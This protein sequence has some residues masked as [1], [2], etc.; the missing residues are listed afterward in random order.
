ALYH[1]DDGRTGKLNVN[2]APTYI[3]VVF[4]EHDFINFRFTA[5]G[6]EKVN[7]CFFLDTFWQGNVQLFGND[8]KCGALYD[9]R[10]ERNE[11]DN[12]ENHIGL[13]NTCQQGVCGEYD[14][15]RPAQTYPGDVP[16]PAVF[17]LKRK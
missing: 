10:S 12:V 9:D 7:W 4:R 3:G 6:K 8:G 14:W 13:F 5:I 16:P 11:E 2:D 15:D 1:G 17:H